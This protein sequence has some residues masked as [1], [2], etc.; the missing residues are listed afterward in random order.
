[1]GIQ[2]ACMEEM[3][4]ELA[5]SVCAEWG[6]RCLC[7][8]RYEPRIVDQKPWLRLG[9]AEQ[10]SV[11]GWKCLWM[12]KKVEMWVRDGWQKVVNAT[13]WHLKCLDCFPFQGSQRR[14]EES[15]ATLPRGDL[16]LKQTMWPGFQ[17]GI[18]LVGLRNNF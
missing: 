16:T 1:M 3:A 11:V 12:R 5:F 2:E 14:G 7:G 8:G 6:E 18:H 15:P 9:S 17:V 13:P 4:L 10:L